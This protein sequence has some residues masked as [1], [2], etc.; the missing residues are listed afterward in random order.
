MLKNNKV[1]L[2]LWDAA[3]KLHMINHVSIRLL[4]HEIGY[5]NLQKKLFMR[6]YCDVQKTMF[7][8]LKRLL[9]W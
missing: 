4:P 9:G 5:Y 2:I 6:S 7:Q 3:N 8:H 1:D